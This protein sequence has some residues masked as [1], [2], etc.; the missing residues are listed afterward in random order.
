MFVTAIHFH[1]SLIFDLQARLEAS[2]DYKLDFG[3]VNSNGKHSCLIKDTATETS[4]SSTM[5]QPQLAL[6]IFSPL[7]SILQ[8]IIE[9]QGCEF[10]DRMLGI[11]LGNKF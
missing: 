5:I 11:V 8:S 3:E 10:S 6:Q 9:S 1:P 4:V 2:L 7:K